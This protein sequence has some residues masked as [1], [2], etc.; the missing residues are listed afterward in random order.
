MTDPA[1]P[2][3]AWLPHYEVLDSQQDYAN[4]LFAIRRDRCRSRK[5]AGERS[6]FVLETCAW[7]NV[8]PVT[9]SGQVVL[10]QQYRHGLAGYTLEIPG[11]M[12]DASDLDPLA[13]AQRELAEETGYAAPQ[14]IELAALQ[15]N[16]AIQSNLC[17]S[18]LALDARPSLAPAPEEWEDLR[19]VELPLAEIPSRVAR[20]EI[21][22]SL[23]LSAFYLYDLWRRGELTSAR[24]R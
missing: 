11:G 14:W 3:A 17:H 23:V 1:Q 15:P 6:Y 21:R 22:H 19:I 12:V 24:E 20:G 9:A 7:I 16:P 10:V 5:G 13:A 18:F 4:R 8:L 2:A